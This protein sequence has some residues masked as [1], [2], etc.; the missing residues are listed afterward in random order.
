MGLRVGDLVKV[1]IGPRYY[2]GYDALVIGLELVEDPSE[3]LIKE[4]EPNIRVLC[5]EETV[6]LYAGWVSKV[7]Q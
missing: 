6:V 1:D 3:D 2:V 4:P 5:R 7:N